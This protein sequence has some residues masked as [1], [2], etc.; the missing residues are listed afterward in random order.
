ME[1]DLCGPTGNVL[2]TRGLRR[3]VF[4]QITKKM[5]KSSTEE[6]LSVT[7]VRQMIANKR[8][9]VDKLEKPTGGD[10]FLFKDEQGK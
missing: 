8:D 9:V 3:G 10:I 2:F 5:A 4:A 6:S 7:F 1:G